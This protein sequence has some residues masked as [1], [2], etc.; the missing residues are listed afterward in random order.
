MEKSEAERLLKRA[1]DAFDAEEWQVCAETYEQVLAHYP[2]ERPSAAWWYDAALAYKFLRN[3]PKA[4]ELGREAAARAE[5]GENDPAFWNLGIAAT[6][7]REWEVA[8]DAWEGFGIPMPEG[9]GPVDVDGAFGMT[10]V[11]LDTDGEQEVVW[12]QR[13]C[14]TR[15]QI[16]NVP[17]TEG[18]RFGEIVVH[19]GEPK[20]ERVYQGRSVSVF[21]ELVLF[22]PSALPTLEVT[23]NAAEVADVHAL[24]ELF[25]DRDFGAEPTSSFTMHCKCCSEGSIEYEEGG[26]VHAGAQTVA[27]AAPEDD[28]RQLLEQW[29]AAVTIGRSWSGLQL[30]G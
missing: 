17:F 11:R 26:S 27:L 25:A 19:D 7:L 13:L 15:A 20:G 10:C 8:R 28:A 3:W 14:P 9:E 4:Y 5:R 21:D 18:R 6:V 2:D 16:V 24:V 1:Q 29:A 23:V 12:A 30:I 22:E